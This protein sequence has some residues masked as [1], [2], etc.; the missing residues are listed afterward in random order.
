L[1][2]KD[3]LK[4]EALNYQFKHDEIVNLK[5]L[6][7]L[8]FDSIILDDTQQKIFQEYL[9]ISNQKSRNKE[10]LQNI[11]KRIPEPDIYMEGSRW[12]FYVLFIMG[13]VLTPLG[14]YSWYKKIHQPNMILLSKEVDKHQKDFKFLFKDKHLFIGCVIAGY[15]LMYAPLFILEMTISN[16]RNKSNIEQQ[17]MSEQGVKS[18]SSTKIE[19]ATVIIYQ[20]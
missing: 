8:A 10:L 13:I 18:N 15:L 7:V 19:N 5:E 14:F 3:S 12:V 20:K 6:N 4:I 2:V 11:T 17:E 16:V 1:I 9:I